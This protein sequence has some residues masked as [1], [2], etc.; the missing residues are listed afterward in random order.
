MCSTKLQKFLFIILCSRVSSKL[1]GLGSIDIIL[2]HLPLNIIY[3]CFSTTSLIYNWHYSLDSGKNVVFLWSLKALHSIS[4]QLP[5]RSLYSTSHITS[6][7]AVLS[8]MF[9]VF[10]SPC[11]VFHSTFCP[12]HSSHIAFVH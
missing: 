3:T 8:N 5:D 10:S 6:F 7:P 11:H 4:E 2:L 1:D 12:L 9:P